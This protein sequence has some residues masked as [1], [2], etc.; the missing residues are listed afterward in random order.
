MFR[1][2][3]PKVTVSIPKKALEA[4]FDECDRYDVDETGGR[5]VGTYHKKGCQYHIDVLGVIAPGPNARRAPTSF[6]QDGDYQERVFREAEKDHP[7]LEHLGN[8]HTHHVNGLQTLSSGDRSTYHRIVNHDKHNTDFFYALLVTRKNDNRDWRYEIKHY[9]LFRGDDEIHG[10]EESQIRVVDPS[11][12]RPGSSE[13][14]FGTSA[15]HQET[16]RSDANLE[17]VKDQEFFSEFY[18]GLQPAFSRSIGAVYWKGELPLIDGSYV[19]VL[20]MESASNEGPSYSV[21][22]TKPKGSVLDVLDGYKERTF[23][24]AR[25][26]VLQLERDLNRELYRRARG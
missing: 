3:R 9:V 16:R 18:P 13:I 6:F 23:R 8:W 5:I 21:T 10:I 15:S 7:K 1:S 19:D 4:I 25:H 14:V 12:P 20:A 26:A 22:I 24:S 17:R 11:H 2:R